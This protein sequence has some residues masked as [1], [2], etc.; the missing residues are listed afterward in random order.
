MNSYQAGLPKRSISP[1]SEYAIKKARSDATSSVV[2]KK[3]E[4]RSPE[5]NLRK[6]NSTSGVHRIDFEEGGPRPGSSD[7]EIWKRQKVAE[8]ASNFAIVGKRVEYPCRVL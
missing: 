8:A 2:P 3:S 4:T 7:F 5:R 6:P 1:Y